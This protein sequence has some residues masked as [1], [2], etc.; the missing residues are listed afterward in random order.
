MKNFYK[1]SFWL[2]VGFCNL[3]QVQAQWVLTNGWSFDCDNPMSIVVSQDNSKI[4]TGD[5]GCGV[6]LSTDDG[7][8]WKQINNGLLE[9][10]TSDSL[11]QIQARYISNLAFLFTSRD[12]ALFTA[13]YGGVYRLNG[14]TWTGSGFSKYSGYNAV[15]QLGIKHNGTSLLAFIGDLGMYRSIND[16]AI[17][18]K[19]KSQLFSLHPYFIITS[20]N[21]SLIF[22]GGSFILPSGVDTA[23]VL[24]SSDNGDNWVY[25]DSG[26]TGTRTLAF[27]FVPNGNGGSD[28]LAGTNTGIFLSKDNGYSWVKIDSIAVSALAKSPDGEHLFAGGTRGVFISN[29][30]GR[31]WTSIDN[32]FGNVTCLA[33]SNKYIYAGATY[34]GVYRRL[35]SEVTSIEMPITTTPTRFKME[36]NYPNPF[37]PTTTI[38]YEIPKAAYV[39]LKVYDTIGNEVEELVNEE[40]QAGN[41]KVQFSIGSR[42]LAS[43]IYFYQIR[44]GSHVQTKKMLL[45]K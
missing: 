30:K 2:L 23:V 35:L 21:D 12:N 9:S 16:G 27:T 19:T 31:T 1:I 5:F 38:K 26:L 24:E 33:V 42:Q 17:W 29:N 14:S 8:N 20:P 7:L 41:Y 6:L 13:T 34:S 3:C 4:Y 36:Q 32:I 37:N 22:T 28:L 25:A 40:Q 45:L 18:T 11:N 44:A 39:T 10:G 15:Y 43:G